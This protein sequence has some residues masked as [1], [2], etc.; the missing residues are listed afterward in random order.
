MST[1][2]IF[3]RLSI[4]KAGFAACVLILAGIVLGVTVHIGF[5]ALFGLGA[6]G[7]GFLREMGLLNDLDDMQRAASIRAGYRA[8]LVSGVFLVTA[9]LIRNWGKLDLG[10]DFV[11]ASLVVCLMVVVFGIAYSL[12]FW[13]VRQ[14]AT[15]VLVAFGLFWAFFVGL[16]HANEPMALLVE[17]GAV[18]VPFLIGAWLCRRWPKLGGVLVLVAAGGLIC[19]FRLYQLHPVERLFSRMFVIFLVPLPLA[20][21]GISLLRYRKEA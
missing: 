10:D 16:S 8:Y 13:D 12:H 21:I 5:L 18:V 9:T 4:S 6:F 14:A 15:F 3:R 20:A 17:G 1:G 19:L 7:P 2:S 11:P